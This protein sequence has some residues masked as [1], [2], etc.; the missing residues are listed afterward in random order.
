MPHRSE[1]VRV[2][3]LLTGIQADRHG[4]GDS[5]VLAFRLLRARL[6]LHGHGGE[7]GELGDVRDYTLSSPGRVR[8]RRTGL[9][10]ED[11]SAV[12]AGDLDDFLIAGLRL[13]KLPE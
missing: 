2:T 13:E 4:S 11:A 5:R 7:P 10:R 3:H 6:W 12:L 1:W 8:D 9:V